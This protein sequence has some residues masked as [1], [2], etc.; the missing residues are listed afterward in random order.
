MFLASKLFEVKRKGVRDD[1]FTSGILFESILRTGI[2]QLENIS[3]ATDSL[4]KC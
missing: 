4:R 1:V 3:E 2:S